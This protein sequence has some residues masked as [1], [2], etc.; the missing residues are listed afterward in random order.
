MSESTLDVHGVDWNAIRAFI[1]YGPP[2]AEFVF[3]GMEEGL[4]SRA[5]LVADLRA[6]SLYEP[7]MDLLEAQTALGPASE[8]VGPSAKCQRTWRPMADLMLRFE[9]TVPD[10]K[11]RNAYQ[12]NR[13]GRIPG[14]TLLCELLPY[15][16]TNMRG[17]VWE[18]LAFGQYE[19]FKAYRDALLEDRI[20]LLR[21]ELNAYPRRLVVLYGARYWPDYE[22]LVSVQQWKRSGRF[23]YGKSGATAV[24]LTWHLSG[25][26][27]NRDV[28]LE[29]FYR[30]VVSALAL[31]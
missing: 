27:F 25:R 20:T 24:V 7:Y 22:R 26:A 9:G 14:R 2:G 13:L 19:S 12:G 5:D 10:G 31:P 16:R 30:V 8:Y 3:V 23:Q 29:E 15:P 1:G 18:Y 28:D 17:A 11:T 4:D 6:R 21:A